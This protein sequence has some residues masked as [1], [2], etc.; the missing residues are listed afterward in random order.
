MYQLPLDNLDVF[1]SPTRLTQRHLIASSEKSY[2]LAHGLL[3]S[4]LTTEPARIVRFV[5]GLLIEQWAAVSTVYAF[6]NDPAH[7]ASPLSC[8]ATTKGNSPGSAKFPPATRDWILAGAGIAR[9]EIIRDVTNK[10]AWETMIATD[11]FRG[12]SN[13]DEK[14]GQDTSDGIDACYILFNNYRRHGI[15]SSYIW[16]KSWR[17]RMHGYRQG[18]SVQL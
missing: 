6:S 15:P 11:I 7:H 13:F 14:I 5:A 1:L 8:G 12:K 2:F 9:V 18:R 16:R 10:S 4:E 3:T 17:A